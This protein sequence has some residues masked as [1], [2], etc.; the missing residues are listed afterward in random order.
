MTAPSE[1]QPSKESA[2]PRGSGGDIQ[3][4]GLPITDIEDANSREES[5]GGAPAEA[6][7]GATSKED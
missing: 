1:N 3:S 5:E 4:K 2:R 6:S 7:G